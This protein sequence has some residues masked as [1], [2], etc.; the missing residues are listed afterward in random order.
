MR[1]TLYQ[2]S[3]RRARPLRRPCPAALLALACLCAG[4]CRAPTPPSPSSHGSQSSPK[5]PSPQAPRATDSNPDGR[6]LHFTRLLAFCP[7]RLLEYAG[8]KLSA[9]TA[10]IGEVAV[11]EVER[12]YAEGERTAKLRIVDTSLNH[13]VRAPPPGPAFEDQEKIGRPLRTA[14]A[15]GYA[16]FEKEG[17]RAMANL[18]VADRVLVTLTCENA[19]GPEEVERLAAALDLRSLESLVLAQAAP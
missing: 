3:R 15:S 17:R 9:S 13:G 19:R 10:Q 2:E 1:A 16:E 6:S 7:E 11:S 18:I 5:V 12:T 4:A 14:G 8:G